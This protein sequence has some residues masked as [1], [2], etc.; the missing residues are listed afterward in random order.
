MLRL[1]VYC[2]FIDRLG[3]K[4]KDGMGVFFILLFLKLLNT[5]VK[6]IVSYMMQF[7][8]AI[9][10]QANQNKYFAS[11][12]SSKNDSVNVTKHQE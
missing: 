4:L 2:S 12:F 5:S 6:A 11:C 7:Q 10:Q 8:A 3:T 9:H 1:Q